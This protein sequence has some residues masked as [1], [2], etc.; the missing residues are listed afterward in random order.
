MTAPSHRDEV[1]L[2]RTDAYHY[3][4][5]PGR[6]ARY[7][8]QRRDESRLL[9]VPRDP[10]PLGHLLFSDLPTLLEPGDLL[11]LNESRVLPV[12]LLGRKPTGAACEILLLHPVEPMVDSSRDPSMDEAVA[13]DADE[14]E[15]VPR[16][17]ALVRPGSKLKAGRRVV[18]APGE[19]EVVVEEELPDGSRVVRI[20][21]SLPLEAALE[22]FG[23]IPLP[24]YLERE[25]EPVDRVRYQTVFARVP[26]SAAAP[27]AGLHFTPE[28][29]AGIEA[30]GVEIARV[31][32]HV[33]AGTF[34]PVEA[35]R[36]EE[37]VMHREHWEVPPAAAEALARTRA[38]GGRIW[39]VGTTVVRTLE[40]AA[41]E[42][43]E[44]NP[45][46]GE[47]RLFIRPGY[48]FRVVE[49]LITNFHLPRSTLLMLVAAFAGH[50][51]TLEAYQEA[52]Q[53]G[54]R[55]FSYG[56]AMVIPP[57]SETP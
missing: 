50:R 17:E 7:P 44:V 9:V 29:L 21:S 5:P 22:C 11:V 57:P 51:R 49:G 39:A 25:E 54:Y 13:E 19:L 40:S 56:D 8:A 32:L 37:H 20:E 36:V 33:G 28:L 18:V 45:G 26:G 46:R 10:H 30:R 55:F 15:D 48:R 16:W 2:S 24:P 53:E 52:I 42:A 31:L 43:G 1:D 14:D 35:D 38:R 41:D 3:D 6:I 4:L 47:T 34:R 23:H 12:R 27:T